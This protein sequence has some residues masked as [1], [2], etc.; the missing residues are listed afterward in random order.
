MA[1]VGPTASGKSDL[2]VFLAKKFGGEVISAD[3]RQVYRGLD[4]GSGKITG[5]EMKGIPHY[6]LD[7]ADPRRQRFSADDF[8]KLAGQAI[9]KIQGRGKLPI[10]VGGTGFYIDVLAGRAVFPNVPPN[11]L[12]RKKFAGKSVEELFALLKKRDPRRAKSI[13]RHNKVRLIRA[14]EIIEALGLV[15]AT[16]AMSSKLSARNFVF[17]GLKPRDLEEK[18]SKR[19]RARL[20]GIIRESKKLH[21]QGLS[22]KRMYELGLEYRY[23]AEFL[24]GKLDKDK[25]LEKLEIAIRQYAKR[26]MTWFK[27]NPKIKWFEPGER[28]RILKTSIK[29]LG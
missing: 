14:L 7:T 19:L 25:M 23:A 1:I 12:L 9:E 4:I 6:L 2:G 15:P 26:Q 16:E 11:P 28:E 27:R 17:I 10:V 13:D 29:L 18:I 20:D 21:K 3:S 8:L 22:Y 24:R 5:E